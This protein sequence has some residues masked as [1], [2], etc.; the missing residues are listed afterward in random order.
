MRSAQRG[1]LLVGVG[2]LAWVTGILPG[3]AAERPHAFH[4]IASQSP[5]RAAD[6][7][8]TAHT[9]KRARLS[10]FGGKLVLLYFGYTS[11]PGVC[12]TTLAEISQA[13]KTL[14]S[15][16]AANVQVIMVSVDPEQDTP[17][18]LAAYLAHFNVSCLGMTGTPSEVAAVAARYGIYYRRS[19]GTGGTGYVVDHTSLVIVVHPSGDVRLLFP[20]GT[21]AKAMAD[22][23]AH[24]LR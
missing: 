6:F 3:S 12:P 23:L 21:P 9:G 1:I 22:D 14:G 5:T 8:L 2:V 20:F 15:K 11:C 4:G 19:E 10:D 13:L 17:E 24:L 18:R 7:E 16:K